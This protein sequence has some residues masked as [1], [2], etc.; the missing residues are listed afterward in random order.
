M[1]KI[2][3]IGLFTLQILL[4]CVQTQQQQQ[5][6]TSL[7]P[8]TTR[9]LPLTSTGQLTLTTTPIAGIKMYFVKDS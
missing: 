1:I 3:P 8:L 2:F 7:V 6:T 9:Q 4:N 5:T